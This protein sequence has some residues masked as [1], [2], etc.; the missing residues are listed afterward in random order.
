MGT[1]LNFDQR[2]D[3]Q[4]QF[5]VAPDGQTYIERQFCHYPFHICRAQYP[6]LD[7]AGLATIYLQS[8]AGGIFAHDSLSCEFQ[9]LPQSQV[10]ITTQSSTI[11]HRMDQGEAG[12]KVI[13]RAEENSFLEYMPDPMIL[14]PKARMYSS[15]LVQI[16]P[17]AT[18]ILADAFS[19]HNPLANDELFSE[20]CNETRIEDTA[21]SLKCLDRYRV[22]GKQFSSRQLGVMGANSVQ[23]TFLLLNSKLD[24]RRLCDLLRNFLESN[25]DGYSGVSQLPNDTGIWV[26]LLAN[27]A[28]SLRAAIQE[29]WAMSRLEL[30]GNRPCPRRK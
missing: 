9:A 19:S 21:G 3:L 14:F 25:Y 28:F 18:V 7:P 30:T 22:S 29:L 23:G 27:D 5:T 16:H 4:L 13:I 6:D 1:A 11:V 24:K 2:F 17:T 20:Y 10:H 26:R 8:S 15:L 12:H